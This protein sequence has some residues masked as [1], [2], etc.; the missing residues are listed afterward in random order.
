M[1][2]DG[3]DLKKAITEWRGLKAFVLIRGSMSRKTRG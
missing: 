1:G 2:T 3:A